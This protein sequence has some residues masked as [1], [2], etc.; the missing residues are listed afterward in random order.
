MRPFWTLFGAPC[1]QKGWNHK[2][3]TDINK[4]INTSTQ[5]LLCS[6]KWWSYHHI[7]MFISI[8][9]PHSVCH[10]NG[11]LSRTD[12]HLDQLMV[13]SSCGMESPFPSTCLDWVDI[14]MS[15]GH[16]PKMQHFYRDDD[17]PAKNWGTQFPDTFTSLHHK[18]VQPKLCLLV[19]VYPMK[20]MIMSLPQKRSC[21]REH[22]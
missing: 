13:G 14:D 2:L 7:S 4:A 20:T 16:S 21:S 5:E 11:I 9:L 17:Q 8:S 15:L 18:V 6:G 12:R 10:E 22:N 19:Y 1:D 3:R